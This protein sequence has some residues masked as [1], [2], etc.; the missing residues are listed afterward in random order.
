MKIL[1]T[2]SRGVV[3]VHEDGKT[4]EMAP[5]Q[6][7][8]SAGGQ[9][10][11]RIGRNVL[12]FDKNGKFDGTESSLAG[13]DADSDEAAAVR[14][15][16]ER[17]GEYK[18]LPPEDPYFQPGSPGHAAETRAWASAEREDGGKMYVSVPGGKP[19]VRH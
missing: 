3:F 5:L 16:F 15:A 8:I 7:F 1:P 9:T 12:F 13:I 14:D 11:V 19:Q 10:A 17:Q 6:V 4:F 18:G 2:M